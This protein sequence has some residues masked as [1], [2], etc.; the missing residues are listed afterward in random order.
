MAADMPLLAVQPDRLAWLTV[1]MQ[2]PERAV[3]SCAMR[4]PKMVRV[5]V[6]TGVVAGAWTRARLSRCGPLQRSSICSYL[7]TPPTPKGSI[8]RWRPSYLENV[9]GYP[10]RHDDRDRAADLR[11]RARSAP[12]AESSSS[13]PAAT[14][15]S[16][17]PPPARAE[18]SSKLTGSRGSV[19]PPRSPPPST[20]SPT[21]C[22]RSSSSSDGSAATRS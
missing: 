18:G 14:S 2:A 5:E 17:G 3:A 15:V 6:G 22:S 20:S 10:F 7:F 4:P 21:T 1:P 13:T 12:A 8:R 16:G 19:A 9:L 11:R